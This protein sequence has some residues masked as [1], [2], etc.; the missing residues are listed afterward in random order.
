MHIICLYFIDQHPKMIIKNT[1]CHVKVKFRVSV[2]Y[3]DSNRS[4]IVVGGVVD[5]LQRVMHIYQI[6]NQEPA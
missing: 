3:F 4:K 2:I 6:N 5:C 1:F